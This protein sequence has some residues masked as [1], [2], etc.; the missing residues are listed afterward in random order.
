MFPIGATEC[1]NL[2]KKRCAYQQCFSQI[3]IPPTQPN[4]TL[5]GSFIIIIIQQLQ[6]NNNAQRSFFHFHDLAICVFKSMLLCVMNLFHWPHHNH[7][8]TY[9]HVNFL[10]PNPYFSILITNLEKDPNFHFLQCHHNKP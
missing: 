8:H 3:L 2:Y 10:L 4:P 5:W 1:L 9:I 6:F 7:T